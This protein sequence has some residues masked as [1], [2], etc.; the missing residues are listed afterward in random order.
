MSKKRDQHANSPEVIECLPTSNQRF[1]VLIS[2]FK[3]GPYHTVA[4]PTG[5]KMDFVFTL[6]NHPFSND[7]WA[8][9]MECF[10]EWTA[11]HNAQLR[12]DFPFDCMPSVGHDI[13]FTECK[14]EGLRRHGGFYYDAEV[15]QDDDSSLSHGQV[16]STHGVQLGNDFFFST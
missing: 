8:V 14:K 6:S 16:V 12:G 10:A 13:A 7:E 9:L 3:G 11:R 15:S 5:Q 4:T 2:R 1:R